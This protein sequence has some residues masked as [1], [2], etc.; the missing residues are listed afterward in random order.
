MKIDRANGIWRVW[1]MQGN[2][3][4]EA[5]HVVIYGAVE[6]VGDSESVNRGWAITTGQLERVN[7]TLVIR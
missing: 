5:K 4:A 7:E 6:L 3:I 2:L 1:D